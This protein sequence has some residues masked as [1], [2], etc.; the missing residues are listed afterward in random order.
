[1]PKCRSA[2]F[3][4]AGDL[5]AGKKMTLQ[6][7]GRLQLG[8]H[9]FLNTRYLV[10]DYSG[11]A[12]WAVVTCC[13]G[14]LLDA[15]GGM[16]ARLLCFRAICMF[17]CVV[18]F[19][20]YAI[21]MFVSVFIFFCMISFSNFTLFFLF[22]ISCYFVCFLFPI[23]YVF[24]MF[25]F[26]YF[27]PFC[28]FSFSYFIFFYMFSF[29]YFILF[30]MLFFFYFIFS[31][32]LI[33]YSFKYNVYNMSFVLKHNYICSECDELIELEKQMYAWW[34]VTSSKHTQISRLLKNE[35]SDKV[36]NRTQCPSCQGQIIMT[37]QFNKNHPPIVCISTGNENVQITASL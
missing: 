25:S 6:H 34:Y 4:P 37:T 32:I 20:F 27:I 16:C 10:P 19:M 17:F 26:S 36:Q 23:S 5:P 21:N 33:L 2:I 8:W 31:H 14:R 35:W 1:M 15:W 3:F 7:F 28:M 30:C 12:Y 9:L 13:I 29:S 24:Y 11:S 22:P 18:S